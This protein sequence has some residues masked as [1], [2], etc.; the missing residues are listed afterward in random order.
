M[1]NITLN[2]DQ[3]KALF[4]LKEFALNKNKRIH[5]LSGYAGTGKTTLLLIFEKFLNSKGIFPI[6]SAPTHRA[7]AVIKQLNTKAP[8][9]TLAKLF[10]LRPQFRIEEGDYSLK[11]IIFNQK[12]KPAVSQEDFLFIDESSMIKDALYNFIILEA[13]KC[14]L[15][16]LFVGD[17]AQLRPVKSKERSKVFE[18]EKSVSHLKKVE[19]TGDNPLLKQS[20]DLRDGKDFFTETI[21]NAYGEGVKIISKTDISDIIKAEFPKLKENPYHIRIL[22]GT[23]NLVLAGNSRVREILGFTKQIEEGDILMGY[24]NWGLVD[25]H[26][27]VYTVINSGDYVVTKVIPTTKNVDGVV[28]KGFNVMIE[29]CYLNNNTAMIFIVDNDEDPAK[30]KAFSDEIRRLN[31]EGESYRGIDKRKMAICFDKASDLKNKLAFM[32]D[33]LNSRGEVSQRK[34][35]DYGYAHTIHKSQG[36]TY[37]QVLILSNS[38]EIFGNPDVIQELKYVALTRASKIAYIL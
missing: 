15:K 25:Y 4:E 24:D 17:I 28:F 5:T 33:H 32:K 35:L 27:G 16:I 23:N 3:E 2:P 31:I 21:I 12:V 36:S 26:K 20:F 13:E 6:Y 9:V 37:Q 7:L 34:T 1:K 18:S 19:R 22:S 29:S 10:G 38:I 30:I 14:N 8:A 11:D